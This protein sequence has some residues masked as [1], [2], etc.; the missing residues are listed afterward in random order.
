VSG[1]AGAVIANRL[2]ASGK[3]SVLLL[4]AGP[5][6]R[7]FWMNVPLALMRT[8]QHGGFAWYDP[9]LATQSEDGRSMPI[10]QGRTLGGGSSISGMLYARGQ[11]EDFDD[12]RD[13]G[14]E[15]WGWDDVVKGVLFSWLR[16]EERG[17]S[18]S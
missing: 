11:K 8:L 15:G 14:C 13:A 3:H 6:D 16:S 5:K 2:T 17:V 7:Y 1:S 10:T 18:R 4:E 9:S 12:W